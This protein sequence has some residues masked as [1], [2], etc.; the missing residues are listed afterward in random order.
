MESGPPELF[1]VECIE[2]GV[3]GKIRH[4]AVDAAAVWNRRA[5]NVPAI[6]RTS[7]EAVVMRDN[8]FTY[9]PQNGR[10]Y[11]MSVRAADVEND[12]FREAFEAACKEDEP[13]DADRN[14]FAWDFFKYGWEAAIRCLAT[15]APADSAAE[16]DAARYR[17]LLDNYATGDGYADIDAALNNG[18][19]D[20][21]LS[22]AID[23]AMQQKEA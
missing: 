3:D 5:P 11:E 20:K 21:Y 22:P 19:A 14:M 8:K 10:T 15:L 7:A 4:N 6:P 1:Y 9:V 23:A 18:E 2:C 16:R 12:L 17:W 13:D